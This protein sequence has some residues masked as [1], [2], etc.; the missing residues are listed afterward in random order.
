[1]AAAQAISKP[2]SRILVDRIKEVFDRS[3][4]S[5]DC[6]SSP[7]RFEVL[8]QELLP[9]FFS[10]AEQKYGGGSGGY[11][12]R[13]TKRVAQPA[14]RAGRWRSSIVSHSANQRSATVPLSRST[15][16]TCPQRW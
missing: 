5:D 9:K 12:A 1:M 15:P 11:V 3:K 6:R 10:G 8:G 2:A 14:A 7:K 13:Q 4:Q 16:C